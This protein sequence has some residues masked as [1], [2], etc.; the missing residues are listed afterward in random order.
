VPR[1]APISDSTVSCTMIPVGY[2]TKVVAQPEPWLGNPAVRE[3]LSVSECLSES[4]I[5]EQSSFSLCPVPFSPST[6]VPVA[7][8]RCRMPHKSSRSCSPFGACSH[9]VDGT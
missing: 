3:I 6:R 2:R 7:R 5:D 1:S 4:P 9:F 8:L